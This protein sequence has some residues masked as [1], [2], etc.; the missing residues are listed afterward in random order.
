MPPD[1]EFDWSDFDPLPAAGAPPP[2]RPYDDDVAPLAALALDHLGPDPD[3]VLR[4]WVRDVLPGVLAHLSF[5]PA[6]G[7]SARL[8]DELMDRWGVKAARRARVRERLVRMP[9]QSMAAHTINAALGAWTVV[10]LADLTE[11]ERRLYLAGATLHDLNKM[12]QQE[13]RL[14]EQDRAPYEH[15]LRDWGR[16][17]GLWQFLDERFWPDVAFL[18]HNAEATRGEQRA[19]RVYPGLQTDPGDLDRLADFVRLGDLLASAAHH[20]ESVLHM[21]GQHKVPSLIQQLLRGRYE[22]RCHRTCENRGLLTQALHNAV[23]R[24]ARAAGWLPFLYFP[25]GVTYLAPRNAP[26]LGLDGLAAEVRER[27]IDQMAGRLGEVV[28]RDGK[29]LKWNDGLTELLGAAAAGETVVRRLFQIINDGKTPTAP[30]RRA[31]MALLPDAPPGL[32]LDLEPLV[33]TLDADRLAEGLQALAKLLAEYTGEDR[34]ACGLALIDLLGLGAHRDAFLHIESKGGVGYPFYYLAGHYLRAHRGL[35]PAQLEDR[36]LGA[37]REALA[38]LGVKDRPPPLSFLERYVQRVLSI[39][40]ELLPRDFTAELRTY[41]ENKRPRGARPSCAICNS[42]DGVRAEFS[43]FSN[44]RRIGKGVGSE[45]GICEVCAVEELL[46]R[47]AFRHTMRGVD[48]EVKFL[49]LYPS[50]Y[51]TPVSGQIMARAYERLR[52]LRFFD[53]FRPFLLAGQDA[54]ALLHAD[55][56]HIGPEEDG[57]PPLDR[58]EYP[59]DGQLH[60]Y[61]LAGVPALKKDPTDT[62]SWSMPALLALLVPLLLGVKV[63]ASGSAIP[64]YA[65]GHDFPETVIFDGP[66]SYW[67]HAMGTDRLRLDEL[68]AA[69]GAALAFYGLTADAYRDGKGFPIW[70]QLGAVARAL[71]SDPLAVFSYADRITAAM[72]KGRGALTETG[73]MGPAMAE[74]LLKSYDLLFT[75]RQRRAVGGHKERDPMEMIKRIVEGYACFYRASSR[76]AYARLRPLSEAVDAIMDSPPALDRDRASVLL[77]IEGLLLAL[78]DRVGERGAEGF[79]PMEARK[80]RALRVQLVERFAALVFDEVFQGYCGGDR[81]LLRRRLNLLK[82]GCE[83]YYVKTYGMKPREAGAAAPGEDTDHDNDSVKES[84]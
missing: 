1:E 37:Y 10:A 67:Q 83:A 62:E 61:Y 4:A 52:C 18:A 73:G 6:K 3:P 70:N 14:S 59:P 77:Q 26:P 11:E 25:D 27:L 49:H 23:L 53:L 50:Y 32:S 55:V 56:L 82:N 75:Y 21:T 33:V 58:V 35:D 34:A 30:E 19:L 39:G 40:G 76:S 36:L 65:S 5:I 84:A 57:P 7:V 60:G 8:A 17:L 74:R 44:R 9:D 80:D 43:A 20:P 64:P 47:F 28:T 72:Q 42:A 31:K 79:I 15:A 54:R 45:R 29:G 16:R 38:R 51:F 78:L 2:P 13:L 24:R 81:A 66:H 22:L 48:G 69:L 68:Q 41:E 71:E 12:A 63:V 46:R